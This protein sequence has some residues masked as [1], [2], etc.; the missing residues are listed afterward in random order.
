MG[1]DLR[2]ACRV[3][4][5]SRGFS[6]AAILSLALGIGASA[7]IFS[8]VSAVLLKPLPYRE[9][10]RIVQVWQL[11]P[12]Q[13]P[14]Q[15]SD[16]NFEEWRDT[17]RSFAAITQYNT[18]TVSLTGGTEPARVTVAIVSRDFFRTMGVEPSVGRAFSDEE[19][20][21]NGRP[22]VIVS[23]ALWQRLLSSDTD[24][25][26]RPL[27]FEGRATEVVGVM[28]RGLEFPPETDIWF[29]REFLERYPSRTAHNWLVVGRLKPGVTLAQARTEMTTI[30]RG[31]KARYGSDIWLTD[32]SLV[33]L[34]EQM[35]GAVRPA[36]LALL[37]AVGF[38][39]LVA[40]ANV[41]NLMLAHLTAR[42]RELAVRTALGATAWRVNRQ[43]L[44]EAGFLSITGG[45]LGFLAA[46]WVVRMLMLIDPG[47]LPRA[48]AVRV[49]WL[50]GLFTFAV[51]TLVAAGLA[52]AAGT[53]HALTDANETLK[54][55]G[56]SQVAGRGEE[57]LR[58]VLVAV[59]VALSLMLLIG[60]GLLGRTLY[61]VISRDPG[62]STTGTTVLDLSVST[63]E[64]TAAG[65]RTAQFYSQVIEQLEQQPGVT[66]VGGISA[67]PLAGRGGDGTFLIQLP[68]ETFV[69]PSGE[70]DFGLFGRLIKDKSR[71][72]QAE[73]RVASAGYFPAMKIPLRRGRLF[74]GRDTAN[75][76]HVAVISE[77]LARR[78]WPREDPIGKVIQ[79]GN[80]DGDMRPFTVVG[81]V[82]DVRDAG[83]ESPPRP[84][85]YGNYLQR[86][87]GISNFSIVAAA[88]KDPR[89]LAGTAQQIVRRLRPDVP[90][91][92]RTIDQVV[93][94][95]IAGRRFNMWL[96]AAFG[97]MAIVLA[98]I[99]I[100]GVTAF[101]VSRRTQ[102][103][104]LRL[105]LGAT[106]GEVVRMVMVR[107]GVVVGLGVLAGTAGALALTRLLGS[108]LFGVSP[109]DPT[110]FAGAAA[111]LAGIALTAGLVPARRASRV[112]PAVAL[113]SD[114]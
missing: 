12:R 86:T 54:G 30:G 37:G 57:R 111:L 74:D 113:R 77:E 99:G 67:L 96:F 107:A 102:E 66:A 72:G 18:N 4:L 97:A 78:T 7:A 46:P 39:L 25:S 43:L 89:A 36:L 69:T 35:V 103:F 104:G 100:Y 44:V 85:L 14:M 88:A 23:H 93:A 50:V 47:R 105:T 29:P 27:T 45:A 17:S 61:E 84:T 75:A 90:P 48:D 58:G 60:T 22:A 92:T 41:A 2:H 94:E 19:L 76:P 20:R 82:G 33:P 95:S 3:L 109:D 80:M 101:W 9:P 68:G 26:R 108:L 62:F 71:T 32:I 10:D 110:T 79:F 5:R 81:V 114:N 91:R 70:P 11:G 21:E 31:Q 42:R 63:E 15:T 59:Q 52:L 38:L 106:P 56:R 65:Q 40:C 112:D 6:A 16:P 1:H 8:V 64:D 73:Y 87:R 83:L 98:G 34:H 53:R 55:S 51:V 13:N 49:D 28:P 24:L